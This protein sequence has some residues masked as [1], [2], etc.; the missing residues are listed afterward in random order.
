MTEREHVHHMSLPVESI[1]KPVASH[2]ELPQPLEI[3][4]EGLAGRRLIRNGPKRALDP[5]LDLGR[6]MAH[7]LGHV[8]GRSS[9]QTIGRRLGGQGSRQS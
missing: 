8:R 3:S 4:A 1:D 7:D 2:P 5:A 9:G 6:E